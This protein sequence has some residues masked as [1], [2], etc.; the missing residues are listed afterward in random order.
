MSIPKMRPDVSQ[1]APA[2]D[3]DGRRPLTLAENIVLTVK[4]SPGW[5]CLAARC[6]P[7]I[8][9][10]RPSDREGRSPALAAQL[11]ELPLRLGLLKPTSS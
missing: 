11:P 10:R 2:D 8:S 9:G 4:F 1:D 6:G 3:T 7:S 5:A